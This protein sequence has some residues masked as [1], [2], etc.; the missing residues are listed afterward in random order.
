MGAWARIDR[1]AGLVVTVGLV[2]IGVGALMAA[3]AGSAH[4]RQSSAPSGGGCVKSIAATTTPPCQ[5]TG[6]RIPRR[7]PPFILSR[8]GTVVRP[9]AV[10]GERVFLD[11]YEGVALANGNN[12]QYPVLSTDGGRVWRID[13]PLLHVDAADGAEA[14]AWVGI[15]DRRTLFAYGS[16]VVDVTTDR[17]RT[18]WQTYLGEDVVVVVPTYRDELVAYVEQST[19]DRR[20]NPAVTWQYVSRDGGHSWRYGTEFAG[21]PG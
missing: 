10:F 1:R 4:T 19:S 9:A 13:G 7:R 5:R 18:W 16:S 3:H 12:A 21:I 11:A 6:H 15:A 17:G 20:F 8:P 2:G 14:V